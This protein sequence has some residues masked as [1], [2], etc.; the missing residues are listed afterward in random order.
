MSSLCKSSGLLFSCLLVFISVLTAPVV[1]CTGEN[2]GTG[3][4]WLSKLWGQIFSTQMT[5]CHRGGK[6]GITCQL[7][8]KNGFG[9]F[10]FPSHMVTNKTSHIINKFDFQKYAKEGHYLLPVTHLAFNSYSCMLFPIYVTT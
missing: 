1:P 8:K 9:L 6:M 7:Q 5:G 2:R 10:S 4:S 3:S